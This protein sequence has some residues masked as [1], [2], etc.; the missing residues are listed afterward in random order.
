MTPA[1]AEGAIG[2]ALALGAL[3]GPAELLPISSS[4]H[5]GIARRWAGWEQAA[6]DSEEWKAFEVALHAG[7]AVVLAIH[8][9]A[10]LTAALRSMSARQARVIVLA[11]IPPAAAG[12]AGRRLIEE[13]L[14][15]PGVTAAGL[16]IGAV[17]MALADRTPE[18]R[19]AGE[20]RGLD[21]LLLGAAQAAALIP[22][23]SRNGATLA[24]AR[25]RGFD[26]EQAARL[27]WGVALPVIG[28][29]IGLKA[30]SLA[31]GLRDPRR[32]G[33]L[34]AGTLAAAGSSALAIGALG[35]PVRGRRLAPFAAYRLALAAA[36]G[37]LAG[38]QRVRLNGP[39]NEAAP[40]A[41]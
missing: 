30:R 20:A 39:V 7:A 1:G 22:G 17:A 4:A 21:G 32:R 34:V 18:R 33:P 5:I 11:S 40:S 13:R 26:R 29:A 27:S 37:R 3:Q 28:G 8:S 35:G 36:S 25:R 41:G 6:D 15:A 14:S 10:E 12:L 9:R 2:P 19:G 24:V 16:A 23:I 38:R 31:T